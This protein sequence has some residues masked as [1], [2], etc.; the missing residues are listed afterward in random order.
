[1]IRWR[2]DVCI[3]CSLCARVCPADAMKMYEVEGEKK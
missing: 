1:M 2:R 3:S